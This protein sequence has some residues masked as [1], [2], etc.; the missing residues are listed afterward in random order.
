ML[1]TWHRVMIRS[2]VFPG[3]KSGH[4]STVLYSPATG[5]APRARTEHAAPVA[6]VPK[7][8]PLPALTVA[9]ADTAT[10]TAPLGLDSLGE[11]DVRIALGSFFPRPHPD[12]H[13]LPHGFEGDVVVDVLIDEAG[14]IRVAKL[15]RGISP[16]VDGVVIATVEQWQFIPA[17][18]NGTAIASLQEL[19]FHYGPVS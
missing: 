12:L 19:L 5:V 3:E 7:S 18:R 11:G 2:T 13:G 9:P 10:S 17:E 1:V 8:S 15:V 14:H 16:Q 4:V 6:A